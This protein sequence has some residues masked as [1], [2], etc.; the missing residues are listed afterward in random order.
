MAW[1]EQSNVVYPSEGQAV[2]DAQVSARAGARNSN[3]RSASAIRSS[4][5][6]VIRKSRMTIAD[7]RGVEFRERTVRFV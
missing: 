2:S 7:S 1:G 3:S 4:S 6:H 5:T